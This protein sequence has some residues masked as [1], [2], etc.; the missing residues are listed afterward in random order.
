MVPVV[1]AGPV[2]PHIV[3]IISTALKTFCLLLAIAFLSAKTCTRWRECFKG[4]QRM[5][6]KAESAEN[7]RGVLFSEGVSIDTTFSQIHLTGQRGMMDYCT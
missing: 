4:P 3:S 5:G 7:L 2:A 6:K 1:P